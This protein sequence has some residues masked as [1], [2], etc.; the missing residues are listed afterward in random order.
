M[1]SGVALNVVVPRLH[2]GKARRGHSRNSSSTTSPPSFH[3]NN[4]YEVSGCCEKPRLDRACCFVREMP[5]PIII[6]MEG[7]ETPHFFQLFLAYFENLVSRCRLVKDDPLRDSGEKEKGIEKFVSFLSSEFW[8]RFHIDAKFS[9]ESSL[10][11]IVWMDC[12]LT[13]LSLIIII[14]RSFHVSDC[15]RATTTVI[16][17]PSTRELTS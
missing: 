9:F 8:I 5:F 15:R 14:Q 3:F 10:R 13:I 6:S 16:Q 2:R 17:R 4:R 1:T 11:N 12:S 7:D